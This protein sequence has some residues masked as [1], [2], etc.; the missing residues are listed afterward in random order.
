MSPSISSRRTRTLSI[1][2][3]SERTETN[4][5][6]KKKIQPTAAMPMRKKPMRAR[7]DGVLGRP[8][9][10]NG[11]SEDNAHAEVH[12][13]R[14]GT[15]QPS[16]INLLDVRIPLQRADLFRNG[17]IGTRHG[18]HID[19]PV[20]PR[21]RKTLELHRWMSILLQE[22]KNVRRERVLGEEGLRRIQGLGECDDLAKRIGL[23]GLLPLFHQ[24]SQC[25]ALGFEVFAI[26]EC[27][28]ARDGRHDEY[29]GTESEEP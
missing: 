4:S 2:W 16:E 6:W 17:A 11:G 21:E 27:P 25:C 19:P 7:M 8:I 15:G 26:R 3:L 13:P 23:E 12:E 5:G 28:S 10:E 20:L 14:A 24:S 18:V 29:R 22:P 9:L 1:S